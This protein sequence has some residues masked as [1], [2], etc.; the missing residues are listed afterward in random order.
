MQ[1]LRALHPADGDGAADLGVISLVSGFSLILILVAAAQLLD[2][3]LSTTI[4]IAAVRTVL[5]LLALGC[6]LQPIFDH[7]EPYV[8]LPYVL[9]MACFAARESGARPTFVYPSLGWH[10]LLALL[11]GLSASFVAAATLVLRPEPWWDAQL[12]IPTCGMLLGNAVSA[13]SLGLNQYLK[14]LGEQNALLRALQAG[15][16]TTSECTRPGLQEALRTGLMPT[17]NSMNVLGLVSIP[18]M[19]TGQVLGGSPPLVAAKYQALIM[20]LICFTSATALYIATRLASH[21]ALFDEAHRL[22]SHLLVKRAGP[23][24]KDVVLACAAAVGTAAT[25][26]WAAARGVRPT[27]S[28][29]PEADGTRLLDAQPARPPPRAST[30]RV[31]RDDAPRAPP[32]L[33]LRGGVLHSPDGNTLLVADASLEVAA[34][35]S[36]ALV[37]PSG[38]GKSTVLRALASLSPLSAGS[39]LLDGK[40]PETQGAAA[41]R[42]RVSYVAQ[43]G[44]TGLGGTPLELLANLRSLAAQRARAPAQ[45][46]AAAAT[47][48]LERAV[49]SVG[50]PPSVVAQPWSQ[51]SGG[52]AQRCYLCVFLVLAPDVL[53]LDEATSALDHAASLLVEA[54][55]RASGCAAVWVS[56][57]DAQVGRVASTVVQCG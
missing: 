26:A 35:A 34:G 33:A 22:R 38:S 12:V 11:A 45:E 31:V 23:K 52:Q 43:A 29:A 19:M 47:A 46:D 50:L 1:H 14:A 6:I 36:V 28:T 57:D 5:Q 27:A 40:P 30:L 53:L 44:A 2:L 13:L 42:A 3:N 49:E 54:A 21:R 9:A 10:V 48:A 55:V 39:L 32:L 41:Y 56:H 51:L 7:N 37:G 18:G 24:P 15:G 17:L 20:F 8:V 16:A 4:T 25:R